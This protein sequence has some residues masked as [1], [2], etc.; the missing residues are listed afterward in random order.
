MTK[1]LMIEA[2][3]ANAAP[4]TNVVPAPTVPAISVTVVTVLNALGKVIGA[5]N[6]IGS[7]KFGGELNTNPYK[8][9]PPSSPIGS[10]LTHLIKT[11]SYT[12]YGNI[13]YPDGL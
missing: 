7:V 3:P 13:E 4:P 6:P 9:N 12:R 2:V 11:A 5:N 10:L 1:G 8:F